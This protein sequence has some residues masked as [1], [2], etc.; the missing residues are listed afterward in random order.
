LVV[1]CIET[2][3]C[4]PEE[5][6]VGADVQNLLIH[7]SNYAAPSKASDIDAALLRMRETVTNGKKI[8]ISIF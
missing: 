3:N 5:Y 2:E 8:A 4:P 1:S 6:F 7:W